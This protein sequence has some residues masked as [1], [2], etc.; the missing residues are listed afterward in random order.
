MQEQW[1][2]SLLQTEIKMQ[3]SKP[4]N[5]FKLRLF[6]AI[7]EMPLSISVSPICQHLVCPLLRAALI[8]SIVLA[9]AAPDS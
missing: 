3:G 7:E 8:L 4:S 9:S 6:S 2:S 1:F 5:I